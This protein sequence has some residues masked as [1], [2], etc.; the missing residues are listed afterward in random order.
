V[1]QTPKVAP[2]PKADERIVGVADIRGQTMPIIDLPK[3]LDLAPVSEQELSNSLTIVTEF[4][5]AIQGFLVRGVDRIVHLRWEDVMPP[6][7]T[8][9][10]VT[11]LTAVT[12]FEEKII[13]ILDVEKVLAEVSGIHDVVTQETIAAVRERIGQAAGNYFILAVDDSAVARQQLR[14]IFES[15]GI[16]Y[17]IVDNGKKAYELLKKWAK[18]AKDGI[19]PSVSERVLMVISDIEMPEM[20]GYTLTRKIREDDQLRDLFI[21]LNSSLS[22]GFN[23]NLTAK[24][25]A[26]H[27]LSKWHSDELARLVMQRLEE[28][29]MQKAADAQA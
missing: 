1:I 11:Y 18:D 3:A 14:T 16:N 2:V 24:V 7:D 21:V 15:L 5:S 12:R 19:A 28:L 27:F 17:K 6:P 8:L 26:N 13:E 22:G 20:D 25:G 10:H 23:E 4:N 29:E 9:A